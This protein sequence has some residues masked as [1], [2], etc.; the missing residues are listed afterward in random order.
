M[1]AVAAKIQ[2][3]LNLAA[4]NS[5]EAESAAAAAKAQEL[6]VEHN[7]TAEAVKELGGAVD[8]RREQ[9]K[10]EGGFFKYQRDLWFELARLN[11]CLYW[12]QQYRVVEKRTRYN[13]GL[14]PIVGPVRKRRHMV[15]GRT[16]NTRATIAMGQYLESAIERITKERLGAMDTPL[17]YSSNWAVSYRAGAAARIMDMLRDQRLAHEAREA[18]EAQRAAKRAASGA[19]ASSA[20]TIASFAGQEQDANLDFI[21][22]EGWSAKRAAERAARAEERRREMEAYT[23]WAAEHPE[24]AARETQ[25]AKKREERN[26]ARRRGRY[27]AGPRDNRDMGAYYAGYDAAEKISLNPQVDSGARTKL[28]D[29][30]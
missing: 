6:L 19:S 8:G 27:S 24:E 17:R 18:A 20:L 23:K 11:F 10:T 12:V 9:A 16:V 28:E 14:P 15:V 25:E 3:L 13:Q 1:E 30:R 5:N 4:N 21:Y 7:L 22:G 26:A 29:K 2:K